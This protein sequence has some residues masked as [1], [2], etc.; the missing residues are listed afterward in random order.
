[1]KTFYFILLRVRKDFFM[2]DDLKVALL[3]Y[4]VIIFIM[5]VHDGG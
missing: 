5:A 3:I 1:M 4:P 2:L